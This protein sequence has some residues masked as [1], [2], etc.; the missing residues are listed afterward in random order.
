MQEW[1][2]RSFH[3]EVEA[4]TKTQALDLALNQQGSGGWELVSVT[5]QPNP[6]GGYVT[7][8]KRPKQ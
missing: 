3:I 2:Y 1:E 8:F 6:P 7:I 5:A 4:L